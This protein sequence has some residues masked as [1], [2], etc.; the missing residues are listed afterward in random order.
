MPVVLQLPTHF[1]GPE[2][3]TTPVSFQLSIPV[4]HWDQHLWLYSQNRLWMS[5]PFPS[6]RLLPLCC[7]VSQNLTLKHRLECGLP[8][9]FHYGPFLCPPSCFCSPHCGSEVLRVW[10]CSKSAPSF[11]RYLGHGFGP[12]SVSIDLVPLDTGSLLSPSVNACQWGFYMPGQPA[13]QR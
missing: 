10:H 3:I 12:L 2:T 7:S 5:L 13:H 9:W 11:A 8:T 1:I 6:P 4:L